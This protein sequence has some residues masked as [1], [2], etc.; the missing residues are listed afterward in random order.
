M[1]EVMV[2]PMDSQLP[3]QLSRLLMPKSPPLLLSR[4]LLP[5]S[6]MPALPILMPPTHMPPMP[7]MGDTHMPIMLLLMVPMLLMLLMVPMLLQLPP[8]LLPR[9]PLMPLLMLKLMPTTMELM[10]VDM[11]TDTDTVPTMVDM[12]DTVLMDMDS[13]TTD[14]DG[15]VKKQK[16]NKRNHS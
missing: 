4:P 14:T 5:L 10:D 2:S 3:T 11:D 9:G 15:A 7:T 8:T 16:T 6:P 13:D 1:G 12:V